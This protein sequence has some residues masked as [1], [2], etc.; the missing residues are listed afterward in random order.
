V[1]NGAGFV[2]G[3]KVFLNVQKKKTQFV[4]P[5]QMAAFK[6]GKRAVI[7]DTLKVRNRGNN[8]TPGLSYARTNC[9]P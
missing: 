6:A 9:P 8:E 7:G 5:A 4:S 1:I 3:T 2:E